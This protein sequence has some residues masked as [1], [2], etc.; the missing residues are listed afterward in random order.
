MVSSSQPTFKHRALLVF[1][2]LLKNP[3]L[4]SVKSIYSLKFSKWIMTLSACYILE[5]EPLQEDPT[6][7]EGYCQAVLCR[8]RFRKVPIHLNTRLEYTLSLC[9]VNQLLASFQSWR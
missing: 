4:L 2:Y 5:I 3:R 7:E 6:L 8:L 9:P 1:V